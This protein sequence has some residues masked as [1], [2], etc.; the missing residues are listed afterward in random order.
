ML[1]DWAASNILTFT[2]GIMKTASLF[3]EVK[4]EN[5]HNEHGDIINLIFSSI[6]QNKLKSVV[7]MFTKER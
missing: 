4:D 6:K 2:S 7:V 5:K 3:E 1:R